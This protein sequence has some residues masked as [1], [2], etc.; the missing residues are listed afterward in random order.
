MSEAWPDYPDVVL[1]IVCIDCADPGKLARFWGEL[2]A[3][4]VVSENERW[5]SLEWS[6]RFG[7]GLIFQR[8]PEPKP[9]DKNR[10]HPDVICAD[11]EAT[12][13]RAEALGATRASDFSPADPRVIV[14]RDPE[15]NEFCLVPPPGA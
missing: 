9:G 15:G 6:P 14:M 4:E 3:R 1:G 7:A 2:L 10:L 12:A 8:V 11:T 5:A 13:K